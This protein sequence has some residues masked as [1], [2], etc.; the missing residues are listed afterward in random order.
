MVK[1]ISPESLLDTYQAERHPVAA[2]VLRET[3]AHVALQRPDERTKAVADI[4]AELVKLDEVRR[5][6]A[7]EKSGL[8]IRY[9]LGEGHPLLGRRMPDLELA[10][11]N[12][13]LRVFTLLHQTR[14]VLLNLGEPGA[15]DRTIWA[16]RVPL[17]EGQYAGAW[18][19][20]GVGAVPAPTAVLVR[21]DGY[22]A[23]VGEG[24][25]VR[26]NEA[27]TTWFGLPVAA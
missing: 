7:A 11:G 24:N 8:G 9:D 3:M 22:V 6:V 1:G 25:Q 20:P 12:G 5:R 23:W 10:T 17:M 26:L 13:P 19:L 21:P 4:L 16:D 2:R 15:F 14:P 18:E 27:I